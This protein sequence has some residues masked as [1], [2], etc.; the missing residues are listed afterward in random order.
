[1]ATKGNVYEIVLVDKTGARL[2]TLLV[3]ASSSQGA[4]TKAKRLGR[5]KWYGAATF[6]I[7]SLNVIAREVH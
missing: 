4:S 5:K 6:D 7:D 1:M 3:L 2:K